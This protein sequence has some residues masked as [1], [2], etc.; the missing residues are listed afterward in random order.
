MSLRLIFAL[1]LSAFTADVAFAQSAYPSRP[2]KF[3]AP[4]P[5]S[6]SSDVLYR[7]LGQ[8]LA[9][10]L[11]QPVTVENRPGATANIGHKYATKQ[12]ADDYTIVISNSSTLVNNRY[13]YKHL[14]FDGI[15]DFS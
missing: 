12:P 2:I 6:G 13:L 1:A 14:P 8:K 15:G 9:E 3:I 4:F 11:G 10:R 7:L 5:P